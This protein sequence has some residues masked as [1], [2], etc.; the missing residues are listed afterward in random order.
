MIDFVALHL[1][2]ESKE[3]KARIETSKD[4]EVDGKT[5][6]AGKDGK[7]FRIVLATYLALYLA[8]VYGSKKL[9]FKKDPM[10]IA[11]IPAFLKAVWES[12][13]GADDD[14]DD[15]DTPSSDSVS[16]EEWRDRL[17]A[18]ACNNVLA[19]RAAGVA[20]K[21]EKQSPDT[22][23]ATFNAMATGD[24]LNGVDIDKLIAAAMAAKDALAKKEKT[25]EGSESKND[26]P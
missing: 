25:P 6:V 18:R 5:V 8:K 12:R 16:F 2:S 20:K 14:D 4:A 24:K 10:A 19:Q 17:A 23:L 21:A 11:Q 1:P 9:N 15:D 22:L 26:K 13:N 7:K 3:A